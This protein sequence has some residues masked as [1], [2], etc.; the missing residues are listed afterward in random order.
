MD[1]EA[2]CHMK[3]RQAFIIS[4]PFFRRYMNVSLQF[5]R[6]IIIPLAI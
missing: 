1:E 4:Y 6:T 3:K 2:C 5:F